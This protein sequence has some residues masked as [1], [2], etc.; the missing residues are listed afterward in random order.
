MR[1]G[2]LCRDR[3]GAKELELRF[4]GDEKS[5]WL[6]FVLKDGGSW[7]DYKGDNYHVPLLPGQADPAA[8][9][10]MD[11]SQIP[12]PPTEL[13]GIWAYIK[14]ESDGCPNRSGQEADAEYQR[15]IQ[16]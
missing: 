12:E 16:A 7:Y 14:W 2:W 15:S 8:K 10:Q 13:C 3:D 5:D 6:N 1:D 11:E 4:K 9:Q